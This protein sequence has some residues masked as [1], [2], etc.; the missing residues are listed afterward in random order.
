[1]IFKK[2]KALYFVIIC[3]VGI[4]I[5]GFAQSNTNKEFCY[6]TINSDDFNMLIETNDVFIIDVRLNKEF[7]KERI[8]GAYLASNRAALQTILKNLDKNTN[9]LVYCEQ[10][11]RS[12]TASEIICNGLKFKN[13]YN[14][15]GGIIAWKKRGY[16]VDNSHLTK[17]TN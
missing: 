8:K 9:I 13:I 6:N 15:K 1:M 2:M 16:P 7:R 14:L 5:S 10:G 12:K 4:N 3:F 17:L 11:D